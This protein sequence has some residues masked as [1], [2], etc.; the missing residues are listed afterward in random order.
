GAPRCRTSDTSGAWYHAHTIRSPKPAR[1]SLAPTAASALAWRRAASR[2]RVGS[3]PGF[4]LFS[5]RTMQFRQVFLALL[6]CTTVAEAR[7][8]LSADGLARL[9]RYE[10][11]TF[12]DAGGGGINKGKAIGVFDATPDEVFRVATEYE[13]YP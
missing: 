4:V 2:S 11:L 8:A 13:R 1:A 5:S 7:P 10:V 12:T 6:A 3:M 9:G